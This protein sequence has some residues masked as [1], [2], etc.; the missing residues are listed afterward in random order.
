VPAELEAILMRALRRAPSERYATAAEMR[1]ELEAWLSTRELSPHASLS[2][3]MQRLFAREIRDQRQQIRGLLAARFD[4]AADSGLTLRV[5][6]ASGTY[7]GLRS[8]QVSSVTDLMAELTRQKR[9]TTRLLGGAAALVAATLVLATFVL[10]S[11]RAAPAAGRPALTAPPPVA[12]TAPRPVP[13]PAPVASASAEAAAPTPEAPP[14]EQSPPRSAKSARWAPPRQPV[15][16][17]KVAPPAAAPAPVE[18]GLLNLDTTPWSRVTLGGRLLG[19]TPIVG[20]SLPAGSHTLVLTNPELG[21]KTVYQVT[22]VAG[23]TTARRV[24]LE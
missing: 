16:E 1:D 20:A 3:L 2:Q 13:Q 4:G 19:T 12:A 18:T 7:T 14:R 21:S 24:G 6:P 8:T 22:I 11:Q 9:A 17:A 5:G 23:M 10:L 15:A